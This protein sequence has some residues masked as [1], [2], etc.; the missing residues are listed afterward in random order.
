MDLEEFY[1]YNCYYVVGK[2]DN[3]TNFQG[4]NCKKIRKECMRVDKNG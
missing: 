3:C 2:N 4:G 1:K